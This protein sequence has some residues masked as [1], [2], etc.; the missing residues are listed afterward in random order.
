[1]QTTEQNADALAVRL[2]RI[3]DAFRTAALNRAYYG[4]RLALYRNANFWL[5]IAVAVG[6]TS[7]GVAGLA[8]WKTA[9]GQDVWLAI[10]A[11]ATV[12]GIMKP[13]LQLGDA[14]ENYSKLFAEHTGVYFELKSIVEDIEIGQAIS[15]EVWNRYLASRKIFS[16]LGA[17]DDVKPSAKVLKDLQAGINMQ[18]PPERF[19]M[20]S[21]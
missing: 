20:P 3:Y 9:Q 14:I 11:V 10:S 13:I 16:E 7:S 2:I 1:M 8:V 5:E 19:W 6:A 12:L 21:A 15:A 18:F 4:S 17:R